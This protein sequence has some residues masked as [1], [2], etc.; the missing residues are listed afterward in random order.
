MSST[1]A[2]ERRRADLERISAALDAA[3]EALGVFTPG[4]ISASK[5]AGG[6]PVTE[7]DHAVNEVLLSLLPQTG[8][9]WLSEETADDPARLSCRRVWVVDPLDGTREF[10]EGLP[11]WCVSIGLVEDGEAVA[12]GIVN[13]ETGETIVGSLETG[14]TLNGRPVRASRRPDLAGAV[15]LAS[16]SEVRRGEWAPFEGA[17]FTVEPLGSVAFKLALVAAGKVDATWTLVPKNDWDIAAGV[18]LVNAA[19]G[20]VYQPGGARC[21]FNRPTT[22]LPGLIAC[23]PALPG[24]I[25]AAI[26][27]RAG[28]KR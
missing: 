2:L 21:R 23:G 11:E 20:K 13:P 5:K 10:V 27:S 3:V 28:R 4:A 17:G 8:E 26:A 14:V 12:G 7:A 16:R 6:S 1:E 22:L 24:Q 9:G 18:A 25:D 19:G 15:V